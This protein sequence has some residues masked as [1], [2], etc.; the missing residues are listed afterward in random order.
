MAKITQKIQRGEF[1]ANLTSIWVIITSVILCSLV[2]ISYC[3]LKATKQY[4]VQRIQLQIPQLKKH[5]PCAEGTIEYFSKQQ[6]QD[7]FD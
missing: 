2:I 3:K 5:Q 4:Q 1:K 7:F 6:L